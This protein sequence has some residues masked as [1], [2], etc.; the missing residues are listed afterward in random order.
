ML[1]V[2]DIAMPL[3]FGI[4]NDLD[5]LAGAVA[6][7]LGLPRDALASVT[8]LRRAVDARKKS[9]VHFVVTALVELVDEQQ[10]E[11][12]SSRM[13][14]VKP[15]ALPTDPLLEVRCA[16][17]ASA[18]QRPLVVGSGPAGLFAALLLARTGARPLVIERGGSVDERT[19]A[20]ARFHATRVLDESTNV[21]FGEGGAGT[22][23]DGKL[24][25]G[26]SDPLIRS[27]LHAFVEHGAPAEILWQAKPHIGTDLLPGIV[28]RIRE[29]IE[30]LGGEVRFHTRLAGLSQGPA[31]IRAAIVEGPDG[32]SEEIEA[33]AIVLATGHSARDTYAMLER[34]GAALERKPFSMGVRIEHPQALIN[35]VQYGDA[36]AHPA[37][38]AADYK[39]SCHLDSGRS[40]YTFCMC[41]G[42]EVVAAAS[43]AGG[44]VV[45]GMSR[46]ARDGQNAN[47]ALLVNVV[48]DDFAGEGP[49][50]GVEL[51]RRWER[52]AFEL[53]GNSYIAP[54][55][56]VGD[57]LGTPLRKESPLVSPTYPLGIALCDL[58][59][60]LPAFV[61]E[62]LREA[63]PVFGRKL[64]GFDDPNALM[65][66]I[67]TRSSAPVRIV[68]DP[69]TLQ[70]P[71]I[72]GLY[73]CGEGAG[74]AGGIMSSAVD[75]LR[76]AQAILRS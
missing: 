49:L 5:E 69:S 72:G 58:R 18:S 46:F 4:E 21:Q 27:V 31:G 30:R 42:G 9:N 48:P 52:R 62:A 68:R 41:P 11:A 28:R 15:Y 32:A 43:E 7:K 37:L 55:Q 24:T 50:A 53:G 45:N 13:K 71:T 19:A 8:M 34:A 74:Y 12:V 40:A 75:G 64:R 51:Q 56:H 23:S 65:T 10:E 3:D 76:T 6:R 39:L 38:G 44:L 20:I 73:P 57:F 54:A 33:S 47:A 60:A 66:G 63:L 16:L 36:A 1:Q 59:D 29:S 22:F 67:E 70:S 17:P 14:N 26:L 25:T 61:A 2:S 35:R